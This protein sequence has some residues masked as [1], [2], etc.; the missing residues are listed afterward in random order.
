[1]KIAVVCDAHIFRTKNGEYWC[2]TVYSYNFFRRF[3]TVFDTVRV[4]ARVKDCEFPADGKYLRVDGPGVEI[5]PVFFFQRP[6][7]F[8][9]NIGKVRRSL[10]GFE[11]GCDVILYRMPSTTAQVAYD[12]TRK[13]PQPKG[14]EV[15]YNLH[16][17]MVDN[18]LSLP[19]KMI[20][21]L[22]HKWVRRACRDRN[23]NGVS[24]VTK[25]IL[26]GFYPSYA[27]LHGPDE[28]HFE[29][30]YSTIQYQPDSIGTEKKYVGKRHW[31]ITHVVIHI[32]NKTRGHE[33]LIRALKRVRDQGYDMEIEFIGEGPLVQEFQ[34]LAASLG[35]ADYVHF[36]GLL[37]SA[38]DVNEHLRNSDLFVYP[39][40]FGGLPRVLIEAMGAGLPCISTPI[41]GIPEMLNEADLIS[42]DDDAAL[43]K[44]LV[45]FANDPQYLEEQSKRSIRVAA[46][47]TNDKLQKRRD[48][49]YGRLKKLAEKE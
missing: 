45:E 4:V 35:V 11:Q 48:E 17:E 12:M 14:I 30:Y 42:A 22:N 23:V 20:G 27:R 7:Q 43:A 9:P 16:D 15:V 24:Y 36:I 18:T 46:E 3:L 33:T 28:A 2:S 40:H 26:Q 44:R 49:F 39:T 29:N 21:W 38:A 1:M 13:A 34:T 25:T 47:Y 5:H 10:K 6:K 31:L 32:Q 37:P 19:R 41:A 8:L